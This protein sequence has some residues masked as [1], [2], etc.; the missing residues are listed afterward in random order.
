MSSE[1][2]RNHAV[3]LPWPVASGFHTWCGYHIDS[4]MVKDEFIATRP[5]HVTCQE[6]AVAMK[7]AFDN[8]TTWVPK[9]MI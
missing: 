4:E 6:C 3:V 8:L 9:L 7:A 1:T 5:E 2:R